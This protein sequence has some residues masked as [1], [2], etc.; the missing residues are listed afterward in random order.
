MSNVNEKVGNYRWTICALV[1]FATTVNYLDRQVISILKP[2]LET[3]I[4]LGEKEFSYIVMAFQGAYALGLLFIGWFID[5][6]GTKLG[7]AVSI[8]IWGLSSM[9][10]AL[11]RTPL[12]FG[13][14]R[15]GLGIGESG[16]FP[17]AVKTVAEWFPKKERALATGIFN[18]GT[19]IGAMIAPILIPWAIYYFASDPNHPAWQV[20]FIITGALDFLWLIFWFLIYEKP[21]KAKKLSKAELAY[22]NSDV[23]EVV[24]NNAEV[25]KVP[26]LSLMKFRQIW[27]FTLAK[28][29]TDCAWWFYLFWLPSFLKDKYH[30]DIKDI[31]NFALPFI[32]IYTVTMIGS[33]SGGIFSTKLI[34]KGWSI[35]KARKTAML[36]FAL[37]II[38]VVLVKY[39]SLWP[40]VILIAIAM[41]SHQ[42]WAANLLTSVSDMFPKRATASVT[43]LGTM[44]ATVFSM[45]FSFSVGAL[46]NHWK[47]IGR[48][49]T[50]YITIFAYCASIYVIGWILFN[51]LAPKLDPIDI[52]K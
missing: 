19:A 6:V 31:K 47:V 11:A 50:G 1:F 26:W 29:L 37:L 38:P 13:L 3:E 49:E 36:F 23:H 17:A 44:V 40:A 12:G 2:V 51:L 25:T 14:A 4:G 22:I 20:A 46:L 28:A 34:K 15:I 9:S 43:S 8:V 48:I 7:Y 5:K 41:G 21:E 32:L 42:G 30:V 35:N 10:H 33:I 16:N 18:S 27:G 45:T 24:T 39:V 52:D